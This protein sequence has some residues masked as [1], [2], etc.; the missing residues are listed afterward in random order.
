MRGKMNK[1]W[2]KK[3]NQEI[4]ELSYKLEDSCITIGRYKKPDIKNK[5]YIIDTISSGDS[6]GKE[7][8]D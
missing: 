3:T 6:S 7:K 5:G 2:K 4:H 1:Q 8:G